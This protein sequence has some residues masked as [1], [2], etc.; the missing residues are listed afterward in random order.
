VNNFFNDTEP[1]DSVIPAA[2]DDTKIGQPSSISALDSFNRYLV[3]LSL[4]QLGS[5][6]KQI[7]LL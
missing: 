6:Q 2:L 5:F 7:L 1:S 4:L 3:I